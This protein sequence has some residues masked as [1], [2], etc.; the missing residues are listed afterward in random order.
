MTIL[1]EEIV[2]VVKKYGIT[3][4]D[5]LQRGEKAKEYFEKGYNCAQSVLGSFS[6]L[7]PLD[8]S[9]AMKLSLPF[10]GGIA[11]MRETCGTVTGGCMVLGFLF[12]SDDPKGHGAKAD[13]YALVRTFTDRFEEIHGSVV[14]R[15]LLGLDQKH[16]DSVPEKRTS[17]YYKKRPC[18]DMVAIA[19]IL[20][21]Q[22][23]KEQ[24][25]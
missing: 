3:D 13:H 25:R 20:V 10:G 21:A 17:E 14:C 12:G 24:N 9:T 18:G 2:N 15:T 1:S 16:S 11:R 22:I 6:D 19:S 5:I 7:L 4:A 8:F 23:I